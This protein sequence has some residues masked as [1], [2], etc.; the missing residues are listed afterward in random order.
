MR[1]VYLHQYFNTAN[2]AGS[3]RSYEFAR[4]LIGDGHEVHIVTSD[5]TQPVAGNSWH[6]VDVEGISVHS[7]SQPYSNDMNPAARIRAF[8]RFAVSASKLARSLRG[9][10]VFATSTPLTIVLPALVAIF[11]R[12]T[13][14][15]MEVRDLWPSVPIAMGYLRNPVV[16]S[17][18]K[19]LER[20]AYRRAAKIIAL[21]PGM[22]DGVIAAGGRRD[23]VSVIPNMS[24]T[25]RF[26]AHGADSSEFSDLYPQIAGRPFVVYTGTFGRVNGIEYM[27]KLASAYAEI[28]ANL[29]FVAMGEGAERQPVVNAATELGVL[30]KNFFVFDPVPKKDL[31]LI[32]A[33]AI[34]C[35]SWVVP[36]KELEANSANKLFDAFA[37]GRPMLINHG[38]WQEKLLVSSGAGIAL[39][40][41]DIREAATQLAERLS[42]PEWI[43]RAQQASARLGTDEFEVEKLYQR[44]AEVLLTANG[45]KVGAAQEVKSL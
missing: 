8:L 9:D 44:F 22:A 10:V 16:R 29:A 5:R 20:V 39:S 2:V 6:V 19:W 45:L 7:V 42:D 26:Q 15:V 12:R 13:P 28:D 4:R 43:S 18:A 3:T 27:V 31:P 35:S 14:F 36:I 32:L 23:K 25:A 33:N 40:P 21:S 17:L 38:G 24:D 41:T 30:N 37:A 11:G 1:I 34:A